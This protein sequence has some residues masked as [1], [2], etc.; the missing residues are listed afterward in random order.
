MSRFPRR[1]LI[2]VSLLGVFGYV[3]FGAVGEP[4]QAKL[5][6]MTVGVIG[7]AL[8]L[9]QLVR[10]LRGGL[11]AAGTD[12]AGQDDAAGAGD[13]TITAA[14]RTREGRLRALE[15]FGWLAG[16][17]LGLWLLGFYVALP[18]MVA[19]YLLRYRER[20]LLVG[21]L[22]VGVALV[23]WGVFDRL[24]HLPF[25]AGKLFVWLGS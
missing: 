16:L 14:E 22:T 7:L 19:L 21:A 4:L 10:E 9:F 3:I 8:V 6:P 15:Q 23:V 17:L 2:T 5:F 20:P 25:P 24:L 12:G 18:L 1:S 13:F 11:T